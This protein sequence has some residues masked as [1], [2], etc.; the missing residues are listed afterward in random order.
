MF[1]DQIY[2]TLILIFSHYLRDEVFLQ[3]ELN[4]S[5]Q[6]RRI[7]NHVHWHEKSALREVLRKLVLTNKYPKRN[8]MILLR[9]YLITKK[10]KFK[11]ISKN[12]DKL[13]V[14]CSSIVEVLFLFHEGVPKEL[15][16]NKKTLSQIIYDK[17]DANTK[18]FKNRYFV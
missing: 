7:S 11:N 5:N 16:L 3:L 1:I 17:R 15:Q 12:W 2:Q 13:F 18:N 4:C 10:K 6:G 14:K 9:V 8:C